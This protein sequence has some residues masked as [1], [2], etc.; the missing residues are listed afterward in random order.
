MN[1][2]YFESLRSVA[3]N[4]AGGNA[5]LQALAADYCDEM[6]YPEPIPTPYVQVDVAVAKQ[7]AQWYENTPDQ[8]DNSEVRKCYGAMVR[9]I[10]L[11]L[12][13][14]VNRYGL[15]IEPFDDDFTPYKDSAEMFADVRDNHHMWVYDGG[16]DHTVLTRKEN[17][18]FRAV[19]DAFGHCTEF[20][21]QFGCRGET[22]A[23]MAHCKMFSPNAR[24]ALTCESRCQNHVVCYGEMSYLPVRERPFAEQKALLVPWKWCTNAELQHAYAEYPAFFPPVTENNP[25]RRLGR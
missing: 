16:A 19:H 18:Q 25:R 9:E 17:F 7:I 2:L 3:S 6:G 13:V 23:W 22:A 5:E 14:L 8:S 21:Y 12:K 24:R 10:G 20:A 1:H 15:K 4:P 11:Q